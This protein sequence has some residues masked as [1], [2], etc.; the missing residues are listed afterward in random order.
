MRSARRSPAIRTDP[1]SRIVGI[2]Q[3]FRKEGE[4]AMPGSFMF[5]RVAPGEAPPE[6]RGEE[7]RLPRNIVLKVRAGSGPALEQRIL[8]RLRGIAPTWSFEIRRLEDMRAESIRQYLTPLAIGALVGAFLLLMVGA[9][10]RRGDVAER[11][12][13]YLR[14]RPAPRRGGRTAP[15]IRRQIILEVWVT[16]TVSLLLGVTILRPAPRS[17]ACRATCRPASSRPVSRSRSSRCIS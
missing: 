13:A 2:V 3:E 17:W 11:H 14:D 4:L 16:T 12:E 1:E 15:Q 10:A 7:A 8:E 5:R 6:P 9:R